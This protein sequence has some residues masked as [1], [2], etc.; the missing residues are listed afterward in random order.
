MSRIKKQGLDYFPMSID[1]M[2]NRLVRRIMKREGDAAV[3]VLL[4]TYCAIYAGEGYFLRADDLFYDDLA[5]LLYNKEADDVKRIIALAVDYGL[6]DPR[7]YAEYRVLT[8][9]DIQRQFLFA[10]RRRTACEVD[11]RYLLLTDEDLQKGAE[12][13]KTVTDKPENGGKLPSEDTKHSTAQHSTAYPLT[14][15]SPDNGGAE[16]AATEAAEGESCRAGEGG[17]AHGAPE[18]GGKPRRISDW[19]EADVAGMRPPADGLKRNLSGLLANLRLYRVPPAE[20][21]AIVLK[22]NFGVIGHPVWK[23]FEPLRTSHGKIRQ[24]GRYLLSLC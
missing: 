16:G 4:Q 24:P 12:K 9:A 5:D 13:G 11:S 1:F 21:Y 2:Q 23:G 10:T 3:A 8:S 6:F 20:Q 15:G 22:S 14:E 18:T 7:L 17:E 19:T